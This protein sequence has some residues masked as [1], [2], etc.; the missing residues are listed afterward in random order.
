MENGKLFV[1]VVCDAGVVISSMIVN[2]IEA[3]LLPLSTEVMVVPLLPIAV[4]AIL[5]QK[6]VDF[7]V[8][9]SPIP[10]NINVPIINGLPLLTGF[11]E[12]KRN[13]EILGLAQ[14]IIKK[15]WGDN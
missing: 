12:A 13:E 4:E 6:K 14:E 5:K 10:G 1:L 3:L 2:K 9:T 11:D 8:S 15:I 7:I